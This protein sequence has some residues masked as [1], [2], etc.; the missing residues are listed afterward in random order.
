MH[1]ADALK[2]IGKPAV[3][4]LMNALDHDWISSRY[5]SVQALGEIGADAREAVPALVK[6]LGD[7]DEGVRA[8]AASAL[9]K[10]KAG[11]EVIPALLNALRDDDERVRRYVTIALECI[12]P[13]EQE[14]ITA[15]IGALGDG[16]WPVRGVAAQQ[17]GEIGPGAKRALPSLLR[18]LRDGVERVRTLSAQALERIA[19]DGKEAVA[20]L[21]KALEEE[22]EHSYDAAARALGNIA[23]DS[24]EALLAL[25][26]AFGSIKK[27][28]TSATVSSHGIAVLEEL[29]S[30]VDKLVVAEHVN[31]YI[32]RAVRD[33]IDAGE[34]G[35]DTLAALI[36]ELLYCRSA[37]LNL[38]LIHISEPTRPY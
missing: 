17:L 27:L 34:R 38:S 28:E 24:K 10:T 3:P 8:D 25:K 21:V 13:G 35:S 30:V 6:A 31:E 15:L 33:I 29:I 23:P 12:G 26:G 16:A 19:P 20:A 14:V 1:A 36:L 32:Q 18:A 22:D 11:K 5:L 9:R 37:H 2:H 7:D 4:A